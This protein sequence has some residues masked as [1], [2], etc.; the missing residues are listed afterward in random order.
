[1]FLVSVC[2]SVLTHAQVAPAAHES[3]GPERYQLYGGYSYQSNTFNGVPGH[4]QSLDGW[5]ASLA[6]PQMWHGLRFKMD[7]TQYRANNYGAAQNAY[8]IL[9]GFQY[10]HKIGYETVFG[11]LMAGDI[12]MNQ[13]WGPNAHVG[14]TASFTTVMGGGIDTPIS[15]RFAIRTGAD[16]VYENFA[17]IMAKSNAIPYRPPGLPNYFGKVN[18]GVVW[19]F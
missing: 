6:L 9:A 5:E 1:M 18:A 15:R 17:L 14:M 4:R 8:Y 7:T 12:G 10:G 3:N 11:E 2:F 16:W 19:K 13:N